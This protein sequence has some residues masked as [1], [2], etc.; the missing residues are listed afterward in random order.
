MGFCHGFATV[1]GFLGRFGQAGRYR[2]SGKWFK[3]K[4]AQNVGA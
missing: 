2:K 3:I 4:E 1:G